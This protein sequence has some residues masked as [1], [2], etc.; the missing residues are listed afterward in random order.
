MSKKWIVFFGVLDILKIQI[1]IAN[2]IKLINNEIKLNYL[3]VS[4]LILTI[5]LIINGYFL[6]RQRKAGYVLSYIAFPARFLFWS[7][8]SFSFLRWINHTNETSIVLIWTI[9]LSS[10]ELLRLLITIKIHRQTLKF[11][12]PKNSSLI[13]NHS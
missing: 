2:A 13:T 7:G 1:L 10:L 8:F 3:N 6:I 9:V 11:A 5:Y 12:S 4:V